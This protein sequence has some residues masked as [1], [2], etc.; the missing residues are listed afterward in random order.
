MDM[1]LATSSW[2]TMV[3]QGRLLLINSL[4]WTMIGCVLYLTETTERY[5][6]IRTIKAQQL[7]VDIGS[8]TELNGNTRVV[9]DKPYESAIDFS[10][11]SMDKLETAKGRMGV[12]FRDDTLIKLT[13]NSTVILDEFV[14][15]PN[16]SK[17]SMALN[18]VKGTGRFISSKKPRIPKDNIKIRTH[19]AT[20]GI[21][22]TDFTITVKE[23]GEALV[24]L[25]PD[26]FGN[27]SGEITVDTALGQVVLNKPYEATT[28]YNFETAPTPAVILDLTIDMIDNM[29]I[30]NPP[31]REEQ[32]AD[33]NN[34]VADNILDVD[35]LEFNDLD[36]DQLQENELE[37]TELDI[38]YLAGNFL[39]DLLDIIQDVDELGKAEKA[40]SADG[41]KGTAVGYDSDTQISTFVTDTHLKFLRAIEDS[42]EMKVDKSGSYNITIEQE[43]KVN[44]ITTNGGSGSNITIKQGS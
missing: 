39:E 31:Q 20:I 21:R 38:D 34:A 16:P 33:E 1:R 6:L 25:L 5:A 24:I 27:A 41:V 43:G 28:V 13:E 10:L 23:T 4:L 2:N 15:D 42:L 26:E 3:T 9:R 12:T 14:F 19:A 18:F 35:L 7:D 17:S 44:Q 30:V 40:L 22:G 11:N 36:E 37:Y 32:E 29:L 8:I